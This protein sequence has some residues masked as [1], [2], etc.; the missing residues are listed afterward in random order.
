VTKQEIAL[1]KVIFD[2]PKEQLNCSFAWLQQNDFWVRRC[3]LQIGYYRR[4][5]ITSFLII[6]TPCVGLYIPFKG[7]TNNHF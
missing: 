5:F 7:L 2:L 3:L 6:H 1:S 4:T